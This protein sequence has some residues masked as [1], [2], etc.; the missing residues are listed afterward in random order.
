[1]FSAT[2]WAALPSHHVIVVRTVGSIKAQSARDPQQPLS[3]HRLPAVSCL[4]YRQEN[5]GN[6]QQRAN[7]RNGRAKD[8]AKPE[9]QGPRL[10]G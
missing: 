9:A 3:R 2:S 8:S 1:M 10:A 6:P 7:A 4:L 5:R